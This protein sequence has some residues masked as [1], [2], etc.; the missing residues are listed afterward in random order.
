V[1]VAVAARPAIGRVAAVAANVAV[2]C[3]NVDV[4]AAS[5]DADVAV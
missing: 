1:A 5:E 3:H 2:V 4:A